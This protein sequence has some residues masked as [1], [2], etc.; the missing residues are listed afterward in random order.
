MFCF[1]SD[2]WRV[3]DAKLVST[4]CCRWYISCN[5]IN[6]ALY[7]SQFHS[8]RLSGETM[9]FQVRSLCHAISCGPKKY[10]LICNFKNNNPVLWSCPLHFVSRKHP[11]LA[12]QRGDRDAY[13]HLDPFFPFLCGFKKKLT[14]IIGWFPAT[15]RIGTPSLWKPGSTTA[16]FFE[17]QLNGLFLF[18]LTYFWCAGPCQSSFYHLA[19]DTVVLEFGRSY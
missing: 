12:N 1:C 8:V 17:H 19:F 18:V 10:A 15:F 4:C 14:K 7:F 6:T 2:V 11:L 9:R 13:P 5:I 16:L 3:T